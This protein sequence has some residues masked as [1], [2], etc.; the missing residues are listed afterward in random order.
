[1]ANET[2]L[3]LINRLFARGSAPGTSFPPFQC[4]L[5]NKDQGAGRTGRASR[6]HAAPNGC[7]RLA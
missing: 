7:P 2:M 4:P 6:R 5:P 1:M 3:S